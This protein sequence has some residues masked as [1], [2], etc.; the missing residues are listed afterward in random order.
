[1]IRCRLGVDTESMK[2]EKWLSVGDWRNVKT[3]AR[4]K[5]RPRTQ[6]KTKC[7]D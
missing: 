2:I 1:M 5:E 3:W 7:G 6:H 4:M